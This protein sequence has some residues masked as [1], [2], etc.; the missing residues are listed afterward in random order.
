MHFSTFS[1]YSTTISDKES[2]R[3][4]HVA[5]LGKIIYDLRIIVIVT[6]PCDFMFKKLHKHIL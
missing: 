2:G 3:V 1:N 4:E 6:T 5:G